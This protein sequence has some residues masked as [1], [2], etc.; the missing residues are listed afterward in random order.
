MIHPPRRRTESSTFWLYI[1]LMMTIGIANG[2][3][4]PQE[5]QGDQDFTDHDGASGSRRWDYWELG[6]S[7]TFQ[8][9]GCQYYNKKSSTKTEYADDEPMMNFFLCNHDGVV[10]PDYDYGRECREGRG[11]Y[12]GVYAMPLLKYGELVN[13]YLRQLHRNTYLSFL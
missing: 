8:L 6:S 13:R 10:D 9:G 2:T 4:S 12:S 5:E 3:T 1:L 11:R 7:Y